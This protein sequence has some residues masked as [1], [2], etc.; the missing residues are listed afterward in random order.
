MEAT[1]PARQVRRGEGK[2][3]SATEEVTMTTIQYFFNLL[4]AK[5]NV[6]TV[7]QNLDNANKLYEVAVVKRRMGKI[8]ENDSRS[9]ASRA[10][11]L[12]PRSPTT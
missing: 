1:H 6:T 8:S 3:L 11:R 4:L 10:S 12:S 5:E 7:Q 2:L 9:F